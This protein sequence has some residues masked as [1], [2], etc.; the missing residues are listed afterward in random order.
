MMSVKVLKSTLKAWRDTRQ[1]IVVIADANRLARSTL[2]TRVQNHIS[3]SE[4][5]QLEVRFDIIPQSN[6]LDTSPMTSKV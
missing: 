2:Q 1:V 5:R 4:H 3:S 6:P